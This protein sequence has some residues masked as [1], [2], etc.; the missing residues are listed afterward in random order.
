MLSKE[1]LFI[2]M[3]NTQMPSKNTRRPN[4]EIPN[5]LRFMPIKQHVISNSWNH[6]WARITVRNA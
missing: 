4:A 6:F 5:L 3:L 2:K 1:T